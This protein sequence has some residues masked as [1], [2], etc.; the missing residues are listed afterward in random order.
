MAIVV[1]PKT[2]GAGKVNAM[3]VGHLR[4]KA[5]DTYSTQDIGGRMA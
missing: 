2:S 4:R 3:S 1:V 5:K